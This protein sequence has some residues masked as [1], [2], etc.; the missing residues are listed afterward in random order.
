MIDL[1]VDNVIN[2]IKL[3]IERLLY[4]APVLL[5]VASPPRKNGVYM[6]LEGDV[7]RYV[8]EAKGSGGLR[9]RLLSK[10]IS[11]DDR[12]AVQRA[13]LTQF[14]DR[15]L[16]R[17][18]IKRTVSARWIEIEDHGRVTAVEKT[19]I[20]IYEPEWNKQETRFRPVVT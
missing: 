18:H 17:D 7:I 14:P 3:D 11:G 12:H 5:G 8:G 6:L 1:P 20:W 15:A 4:I 2:L 19:L 16:R 10:H 9:D 13:F